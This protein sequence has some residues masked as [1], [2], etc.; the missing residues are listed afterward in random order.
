MSF[1][2]GVIFGIWLCSML[3]LWALWAEM[4]KPAIDDDSLIVVPQQWGNIES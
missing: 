1:V 3:V 2:F 4:S